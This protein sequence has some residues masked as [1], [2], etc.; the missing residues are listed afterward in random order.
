[1]NHSLQDNTLTILLD[2]RVD[3]KNADQ[4]EEEIFKLVGEAPGAS[5]VIDASELE[6]ISSAGLRVLLKLK[7]KVEGELPIVHVCPAVNEI[8]T[9]TGFSKILD[10]HPEDPDAKVGDWA[11]GSGKI[12]VVVDV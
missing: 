6:Y 1:M 5:V 2:K 11:D 4:V 12:E 10:V 9:A 3:I 8:L 7:K